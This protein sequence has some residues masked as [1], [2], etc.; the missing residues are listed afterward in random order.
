MTF[1]WRH[2]LDLAE[3][4][5][6]ADVREELPEQDGGFRQ[7]ALRSAV[8][9]AYYAAYHTVR[10]YLRNAGRGEPPRG[11]SHTWVWRQ[12]DRRQRLEG[13]IQREG[14]NL[15]KARKSADYELDPGVNW[16]EQTEFGVA[17]SRRILEL[18]AQ[19]QVKS[20]G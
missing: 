18:V 5:S 17:T 8:S 3:E 15:L 6:K 12:L 4:L 9:R 16:P 10:E 1:E 7:A 19:L 13:R 14:F 11:D 2:L 20:R